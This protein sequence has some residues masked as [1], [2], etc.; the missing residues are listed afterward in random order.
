MNRADEFYTQLSDIEA[1]IAHYV[2]DG[3]NPF[4][5]KTVYLNCDDP[6][7]SNF[8]RFFADRFEALGSSRL[9]A[10]HWL[11]GG[12]S[13]EATILERTD[14][15][16]V[17]RVVPLTGDGDFRSDECVEYL[18]QSDIVVSNPP[19]TLWSEYL[20]QLV[21]HR[22]QF[23][24]LGNLNAVTNRAVFPYLRDGL[25]W[26]GPSI[27]SSDRL[28]QVP[29][30]Y[31]LK[32]FT[33]WEDEAGDRWI[34]VTGV[35]WYTNL[36][37][38]RRH[39]TLDLGATYDPNLHRTFDLFP[40][41]NV[42]RLADI[43]GDYDGVM[44]VPVTILDRFNPDQFEILGCTYNYGRPAE[45]DP[46]CRMRPKIDGKDVYKRILVRNLHPAVSAIA[47]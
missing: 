46:D 30:D 45:F 41:I 8:W 32:A 36:D 7:R 42:G 40:A 34:R 17:K 37:H 44:G 12:R 1:E 29:N 26:L 24:I 9:I 16:V 25:V 20:T 38:Q 2:V 6:S 14:G 27:S 35:R 19:F 18:Q 13:S 15:R 3:R 43:P 21:E 31:P 33:C 11:D 22:K 28:F 5:G 39:R 10:T 23:L 47:A 4:R